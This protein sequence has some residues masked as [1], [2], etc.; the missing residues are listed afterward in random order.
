[1]SQAISDAVSSVNKDALKQFELCESCMGRLFAKVGRG[2]ENSTRGRIA[3]KFLSIK[4]ITEPHECQMCGGI[5]TKTDH[6][7]DLV[8]EAIDRWEFSNFLIGTKFSQEVLAAEENILAEV[9][10]Q[11]S[12]LLKAE[13][14]REIGKR[15][16]LKLGKEPE[17][18]RPELVAVVD[19]MY[20]SV[21]VQSSPLYIYGKYTKLSRTIPQTRWPCRQCGGKGCKRCDNTGKMYQTSVEE[22]I[23]GV[24]LTYSKG[25]DHRFHGMG[26]E[27]IDARMLGSGRPFVL[28]VKEPRVRS[29]DF[30][31]L[32]NEINESTED[33]KV[34][35]LR[36]S[37]PEEVIA[38]KNARPDKCYKALVSFSE[39][40]SE[41]KVNEVVASLGGNSI[42][43]RTPKRVAHRRADCQRV[44]KIKEI[45]VDIK[46]PT[47]AWL[48]VVSEAGTYIKEFVSGDEGRT[49]PSL[50]SELGV[51]CEVKT[52]DVLEIMES[53]R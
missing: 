16:S 51:V 21:E 8:L 10:S 53:K 1:M 19:T 26:R 3:R 18:L 45:R 30:R 28:E 27:D 9:G 14:N 50:A 7:V 48:E 29:L 4:Q 37:Y 22:I 35:A 31:R 46:S 32:E 15:V 6:F 2:I 38:V 47:E 42:T 12:E 44:R 39:P 52:L 17:F 41:E 36:A 23:G 40:V 43:Q 25:K 20:E 5:T 24:A 33:V 11:Q 13:L 34:N 49:T